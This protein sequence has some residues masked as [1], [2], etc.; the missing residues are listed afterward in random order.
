MSTESQYDVFLSHN[1]ADKPRMRR[2]AERLRVWFDEWV[3][4]PG[5]DIYLAI[6]R[7]LEASRTLVLCLSAAALGSAWVGLE[8]STVLFREHSQQRHHLSRHNRRH[9]A[10]ASRLQTL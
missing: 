2:L 6:E 3:I 1:Q 10:D 8:R 4:K 9:P 7:G 5:E